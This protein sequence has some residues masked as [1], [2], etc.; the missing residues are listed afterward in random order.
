MMAR[1]FQHGPAM[2][3]I[4]ITMFG[5]RVGGMTDRQLRFRWAVP[6]ERF[7]VFGSRPGCIAGCAC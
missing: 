1:Q 2:F 6:P 3:K 7:D 4:G 5:H